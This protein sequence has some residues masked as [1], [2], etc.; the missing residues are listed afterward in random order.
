MAMDTGADAAVRTRIL[1]FGKN[2]CIF[3]DLWYNKQN[4]VVP[5]AQKE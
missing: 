3:W 1:F 5:L 2:S 4:C